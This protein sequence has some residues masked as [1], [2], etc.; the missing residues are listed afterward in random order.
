MHAIML[1]FQSS[2]LPLFS[3]YKKRLNPLFSTVLQHSFHMHVEGE[4]IEEHISDKEATYQR[5]I[6]ARS[7]K[8]LSGQSHLGNLFESRT[9]MVD[10]CKRSYIINAIKEYCLLG[11]FS[12]YKVS[13]WYMCC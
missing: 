4:V 3:L 5:C 2:P 7:C 10:I 12:L 13:P 9:F 11:F 6:S 1:L 8:S